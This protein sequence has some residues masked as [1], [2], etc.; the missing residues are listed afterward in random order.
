[1]YKIICDVRLMPLSRATKKLGQFRQRDLSPIAVKHKKA[2]KYAN[3]KPCYIG[4]FMLT[5]TGQGSSE[6]EV[7]KILDICNGFFLNPDKPAVMLPGV[8]VDQHSLHENGPFHVQ[9]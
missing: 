8:A 4:N 5:S 9:Y 2:I 1:M 6:P 7:N 3:C